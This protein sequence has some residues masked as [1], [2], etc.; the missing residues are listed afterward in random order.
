MHLTETQ[1]LGRFDKF[2][3]SLDDGLGE[4]D[5]SGCCSNDSDAA[6]ALAVLQQSQLL[7]HLQTLNL[8][9][10]TFSES[11]CRDSQRGP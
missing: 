10:N 3:I 6:A 11:K 9:D 7:A 8:S 5:L 1:I 2:V 4:L